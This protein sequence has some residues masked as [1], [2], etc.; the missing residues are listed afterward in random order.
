M[1][2][3]ENAASDGGICLSNKGFQHRTITFD[4]LQTKGLEV[5]SKCHLHI[6]KRFLES[7]FFAG[8][9]AANTERPWTLL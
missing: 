7:I 5:K 1:H 4:N 3:M 2:R 6:R 9:D 8:N